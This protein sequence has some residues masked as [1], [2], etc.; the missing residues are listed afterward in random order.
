MKVSI[1]GHHHGSEII[2]MSDSTFKSAKVVCQMDRQ[3]TLQLLKR[4]DK[5]EMSK[6]AQVRQGPIT[7]HVEAANEIQAAIKK[8]HEKNEGMG[9]SVVFMGG[10][11][12]VRLQPIKDAEN[13]K[14]CENTQQLVGA[15][16]TMMA[17]CYVK[18]FNEQIKV[19]L[20]GDQNAHRESLVY[21]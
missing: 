19:G 17:R 4:A 16:A 11:V 21:S 8:K 9:A 14:I 20:Y 2:C 15:R 5:M 10:P 3:N 12:I 7:N 6:E 13:S 1:N 18:G